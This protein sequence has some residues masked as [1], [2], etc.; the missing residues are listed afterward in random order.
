MADYIDIGEPEQMG[1]SGAR[2]QNALKIC[3]CPNYRYQNANSKFLC[4]W[5]V[6]ECRKGVWVGEDWCP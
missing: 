5:A 1:G 6:Y 4:N 2:P 3:F